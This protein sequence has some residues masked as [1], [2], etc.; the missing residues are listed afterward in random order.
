MAEEI[1]QL[2]QYLEEK[3]GGIDENFVKIDKKFEKID[4]RLDI[5]DKRFDGVDNR[6]DNFEKDVDDKFIR[7]FDVF[8]TK[9]DLQEAVKDMATK[10]DIHQLFMA[11]DSYAKKADTYFQEMVMLSHK[12]DR[13][14]RWFQI[15]ADKLGIKLEY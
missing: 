8:A 13:H 15:F 4:E 6:L 14:E 2:T 12:V 3:F 9:E 1:K 5:V 7:L 10:N 11:V